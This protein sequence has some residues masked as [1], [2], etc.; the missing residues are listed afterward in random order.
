MWKLLWFTTLTLNVRSL[1][2]HPV[3]SSLFKHHHHSDQPLLKSGHRSLWWGTT[4]PRTG[5]WATPKRPQN[6]RSANRS[7]WRWSRCK[8]FAPASQKQVKQVKINPNPPERHLQP[9][10]GDGRQHR[11][12]DKHLEGLR[13]RLHPYNLLS[14]CCWPSSFS[15]FFAQSLQVREGV[16][17]KGPFS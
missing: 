11:A 1:S 2:S 13:G 8:W 3:S 15:D 4:H 16:N 17:K 10:L 7:R 9:D 12:E 6:R 5:Q 14:S